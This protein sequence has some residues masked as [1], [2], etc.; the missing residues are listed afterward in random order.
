MNPGGSE[1]G[2]L[3]DKTTGVWGSLTTAAVGALLQNHSK[4][5]SCPMLSKRFELHKS[6]DSFE[7]FPLRFW[8]GFGKGGVLAHT[9]SANLR[10]KPG[11]V[12]GVW[13]ERAATA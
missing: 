11:V 3:T 9:G 12:K 5:G 7:A 4:G 6:R 8:A 2:A 13:G 1:T 10:K